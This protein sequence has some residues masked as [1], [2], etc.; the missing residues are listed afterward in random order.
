MEVKKMKKSSV[1]LVGV[2]VL[3][4]VAALGFAQ[5]QQ[6]A[7]QKAPQHKTFVGTVESVQPANVTAGTKSQIVIVD[8]NKAK[9]TFLLTPS[10]T[11]HDAKGTTITMDKCKGGDQVS[12]RYETSAEGANTALSVKMLK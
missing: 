1:L 6:K 7:T 10:T 11:F 9:M 5:Q 2:L 4:T 12:V 3:L 8:K